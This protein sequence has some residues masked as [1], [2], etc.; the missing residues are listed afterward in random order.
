METRS[1]TIPFLL[2]HGPLAVLVTAR[3]R[4]GRFQN[5]VSLFKHLNTSQLVFVGDFG[6]VRSFSRLLNEWLDGSED[7]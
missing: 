2:N 5:S 3:D 6:R 7:L 1:R 4:A